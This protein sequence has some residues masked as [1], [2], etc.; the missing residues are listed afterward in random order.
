MMN[1]Q[2]IGKDI[3]ENCSGLI[4]GSPGIR[5]EELGKCIENLSQDSWSLDRNLNPGILNTKRKF[6]LRRAAMEF[7]VIWKPV[8][9]VRNS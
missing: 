9:W 7:V 5:L 4:F 2:G 6:T 1:I 8:K 3:E